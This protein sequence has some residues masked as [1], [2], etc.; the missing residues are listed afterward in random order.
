MRTKS[1]PISSIKA[2]AIKNEIL[3]KIGLTLSMVLI[4]WR[5]CSSKLDSQFFPLIR[6]SK[7]NRSAESVFPMEYKNKLR[8][9]NRITP[10]LNEYSIWEIFNVEYREIIKIQVKVIIINIIKAIS[11]RADNENFIIVWYN[12]P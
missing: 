2:G 9:K 11:I 5:Y 10:P 3:Y 8:I 7:K 1:F 12:N 4:K 6:I